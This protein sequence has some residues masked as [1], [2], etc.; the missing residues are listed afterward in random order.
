MGDGVGLRLDWMGPRWAG[1]DV[2]EKGVPLIR[3]MKLSVACKGKLVL[4]NRLLILLSLLRTLSRLLNCLSDVYNGFP[5][6]I[7]SCSAGLLA[8]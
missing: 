8:F 5:F 7:T 3:G 6:A 4:K 1:V 2:T